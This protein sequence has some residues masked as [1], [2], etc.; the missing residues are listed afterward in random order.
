MQTFL[1]Y[2]DFIQTAKCLDYKRLGKQ[3]VEAKQ[4]LNILLDRTKTRGWRNH[5]AVLMW[6]GYENALKVYYN[7]ILDE[8][9]FRGYNNTMQHELASYCNITYPKF[10][11]DNSFHES[12]R[13]N[14]LRKDPIYYGKYSWGVSN[15]LPYIWGNR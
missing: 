15:N 8:W 5:P 7:M 2:A 6:K 13:S 1:P 9:I 10:I 3:R 14:L 11:G 12:H 4:I